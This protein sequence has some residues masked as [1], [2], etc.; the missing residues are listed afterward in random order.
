MKMLIRLRIT[1]NRYREFI[2]RSY[3]TEE[4]TEYPPAPDEVD[5]FV[6]DTI[7][8]RIL[9]NAKNKGVDVIVLSGV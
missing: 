2:R 4:F 7:L 5:V 9:Y 6:T 1:D 8:Q 3:G